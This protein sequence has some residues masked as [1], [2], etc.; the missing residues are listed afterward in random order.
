MGAQ[1]AAHLANAGIPAL[2]FDLTAAIAG[3]GLK[4][5]IALKPSPLFTRDAASLITVAG[6]DRDLSKL[7]EADWII[8]AIVE[9]LDAK[10][11]LLAQVDATRHPGAIVSSNTS[12]I[13]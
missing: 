2:L 10:Q 1:I 8:E 6:L 5:A 3:D 13:P 12:G 9:R 11:A 4:R 7:A